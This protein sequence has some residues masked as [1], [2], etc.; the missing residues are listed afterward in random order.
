[1]SSSQLYYLH[2][3]AYGTAGRAD[4]FYHQHAHA[5][6]YG[7]PSAQGEFAFLAL[8]KEVLASELPT[9]FVRQLNGTHRRTNHNIDA[10]SIKLAGKT[11]ADRLRISCISKQLCALQIDSAVL[12]R[13]EQ[14]M[15]FEESARFFQDF[16]DSIVLHVNNF[17][18]DGFFLADLHN[19]THHPIRMASRFIH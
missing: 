9:D 4:V 16:D 2:H 15:S 17:P 1:L 19:S 8:C 12:S 6:L 5:G 13:C 7:E 14:K 10:E 3:L 18:S 11:A